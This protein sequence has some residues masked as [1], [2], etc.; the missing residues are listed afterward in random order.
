MCGLVNK[1]MNMQ[2][3]VEELTQICIQMRPRLNHCIEQKD[4]ETLILRHI[5]EFENNGKKIHDFQRGNYFYLFICI[6]KTF[7]ICRFTN[8]YIHCLYIYDL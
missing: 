8:L 1:K 7:F 6:K 2:E 3:L 4:K 5:K